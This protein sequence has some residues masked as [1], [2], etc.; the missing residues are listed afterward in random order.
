MDAGDV[1]GAV[2]VLLGVALVGLHAYVTVQAL[3]VR[4]TADAAAFGA[5]KIMAGLADKAPHLAGGF[6]FIVLGA[7][8]IGI[9][10]VDVAVGAGDE[11]SP[12][13]SPS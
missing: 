13:P 12:T 5:G 8:L 10:D 6:A 7:V 1:V 3:Q 2:C 9:L 11:A 4:K